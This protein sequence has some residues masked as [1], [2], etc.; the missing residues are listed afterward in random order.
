MPMFRIATGTHAVGFPSIIVEPGSQDFSTPGTYSFKVPFFRK[1]DVQ[2]WGGGGSGGSTAAGGSIVPGGTGG[3]SK[4]TFSDGSEIIANGGKG[5]MNDYSDRYRRGHYDSVGGAGGTATGGDVNSKGGD[6]INGA[7]A[8]PGAGGPSPFGG[9]G[10]DNRGV[11]GFPGGGGGGFDYGNGGGKFSWD[12]GGGGGGAYA[13]KIVK[14][15]NAR[16]KSTITVVVG[17]GGATTGQHDGGNG[18]AGRVLIS[19]S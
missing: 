7:R 10:G 14:P 5:G 9:K 6:G 18:G 12:T 17:A 13:Q 3:T 2:L 4:I 16:P 19:W 1:M 15:K 11:G 8:N